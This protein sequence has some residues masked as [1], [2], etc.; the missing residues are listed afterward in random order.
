M[1]GIAGIINLDKRP[2]EKAVLEDMVKIQRHRGPDDTGFYFGGN[3]GLGHARLAI[4]DL[5]A[6]PK[7][8]PK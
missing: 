3:F 1:C 7:L 8:P 2:A 4:I 6:N 5:S